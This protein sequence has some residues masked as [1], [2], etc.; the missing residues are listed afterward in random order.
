MLHTYSWRRMLIELLKQRKPAPLAKF[1]ILSL[2]FVT[3][4]TLMVIDDL[5]FPGLKEIEK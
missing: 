1:A 2:M 4:R 5:I 3:S